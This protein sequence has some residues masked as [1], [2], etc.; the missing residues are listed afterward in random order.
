[1]GFACFSVMLFVL[2]ICV[3]SMV[4]KPLRGIAWTFLV[5]GVYCA[6]GMIYERIKCGVAFHDPEVRPGLLLVYMGGLSIV[7]LALLP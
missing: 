3:G 2:G 1:M 7:A 6:V 5:A 4:G